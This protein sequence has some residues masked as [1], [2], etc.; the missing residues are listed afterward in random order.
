MLIF[1]AVTGR[2][3]LD[4]QNAGAKGSSSR[5]HDFAVDGFGSP[6]SAPVQLADLDFTIDKL[7][8]PV[9]VPLDFRIDCAKAAAPYVSPKLDPR[10]ESLADHQL[11]SADMLD[12]ADTEM[13]MADPEIRESFERLQATMAA[14]L[15]PEMFR[16]PS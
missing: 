1:M 16:R 13:L 15:Q 5:S 11:P 6:E 4:F 10:N 12:G 8:P 9:M 3:P 14:R 2:D 7:N